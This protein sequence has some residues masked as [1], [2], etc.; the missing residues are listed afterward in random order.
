VHAD[1]ERDPAVVAHV[2]WNPVSRVGGQQALPI[3]AHPEAQNEPLAVMTCQGEGLLPG[4]P[5]WASELARLAH[6]RQPE[7]ELAQGLEHRERPLRLQGVEL[8]GR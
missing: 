2:G 7:T 4:L 1:V 3:H 8:R 5:D 6:F